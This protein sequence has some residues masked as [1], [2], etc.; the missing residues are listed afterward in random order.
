MINGGAA[1]ATA[2]RL[3]L[4]AGQGVSSFFAPFSYNYTDILVFLFS[5]LSN[6]NLLHTS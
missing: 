3:G 1:A 5:S 6:A 4:S 2:A